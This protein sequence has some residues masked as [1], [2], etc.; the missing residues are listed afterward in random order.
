MPLMAGEEIRIV[1]ADDHPIFRKGLRS[2]LEAEAGLVVVGE[3]TDGDEAVRVT[4]ETQPDVLLL[5][6]AMPRQSGMAALAELASA[7]TPVRTIVLTAAIEKSEIV[8]ALQLGAAGVVL[9]ASPAELLL[10]SI[11][12][13]VAG[14]HWIGREAVSDLV[15]ALRASIDRQQ[16]KSPHERFRLT[17]RELEITSA[18]V[19]GFSNRE[20]ARK[21]VLSEDTVKHH[22]TNIFDKVGASN[23][24]ELALFAVHHRLFDDDTAITS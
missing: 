9:K 5:D 11:R 13:V 20:I 10:K 3:A 22:L 17:A 21:F 18:V 15:A 4:R 1:I 23:R 24:L 8:K 2:L 7:P 12:S 6:L 16:E 14:Q 19:A